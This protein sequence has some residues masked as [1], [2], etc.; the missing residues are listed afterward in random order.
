MTHGLTIREAERAGL[1]GDLFHFVKYAV[2]GSNV[3]YNLALKYC[4][5]NFFSGFE[6]QK[7]NF[8]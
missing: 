5:F 7:I 4:Q 1:G 6:R 2:R 8:I 3:V